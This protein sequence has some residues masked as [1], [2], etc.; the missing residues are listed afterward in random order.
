MMHPHEIEE[1]E[2][3]D[4]P[5]LW[6]ADPDV[7]CAAAQLGACVHS[8]AWTEWDEADAVAA[9]FAHDVAHPIETVMAAARRMAERLTDAKEPF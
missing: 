1:M 5:K 6:D 4:G 8:E 7:C 3:R 9:T 2:Y